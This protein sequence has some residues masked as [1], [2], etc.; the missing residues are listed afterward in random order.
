[1]K[2]KYYKKCPLYD[3]TS[4]VC[5]KTAGMYYEDETEPAGCWRDMYKKEQEKKA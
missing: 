3:E 4:R 5:N 1:M 2:C